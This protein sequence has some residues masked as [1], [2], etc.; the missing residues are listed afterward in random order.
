MSAWADLEKLQGAKRPDGTMMVVIRDDR[1]AAA[2][3]E[4][5]SLSIL[6][7]ISRVTYGKS[8]LDETYGGNGKV[9]YTTT[10][11][12]PAFII[13]AVCAA[14]GVVFDG[15][16]EHAL[17]RPPEVGMLLDGTF[18][19]F[20]I[21]VKRRFKVKSMRDALEIREIELRKR[22]VDAANLVARWTAIFELVA[23]AGEAAREKRPG[24]WILDPS[25]TG[26]RFPHALDFG[27]GQKIMP[28]RMANA[29]VTGSPSSMIDLLA[30]FEHKPSVDGDASLVMPLLHD[31]RT[32]PAED[33]ITEPLVSDEVDYPDIPVIAY[34]EDRAGG[35]RWPQ[36]VPITP[37]L[38][39]RAL[40]NLGA[41][42]FDVD[43]EFLPQLG[44]TLAVVSSDFYAAEAILHRPTMKRVEQALGA[45]VLLVGMPERGTTYVVDSTPLM[46]DE[47]LMR[48]FLLMIE[49]Q[50]FENPEASRVSSEVLVYHGKAIGRVQSNFM[51][52]R[53]ALRRMGIDPDA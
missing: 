11:L 3:R 42:V 23:L 6:F 20:A 47:E 35:Y 10:G 37:A 9:V 36:N 4:T 27:G 18:C 40:A 17:P 49:K 50:Y 45:E 46:I 31:R 14:G 29:I 2:I 19:D 26:V 15:K 32:L 52:T 38:R 41:R 5:R 34:V 12:P 24:R 43:S 48:S 28:L 7:A 22:P 33:I 53:R 13:E 16:T 44:I 51:D 39:Q 21:E 30:T 1:D 25:L 8:V